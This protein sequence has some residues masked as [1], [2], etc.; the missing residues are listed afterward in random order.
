VNLASHLLVDGFRDR[1]DLAVI[2]SNDGDLKTPV[3]I[4]R[5]E[6]KVGVGIINPHVTRSLALSPRELP[7]GSFYQRLKP[8]RLASAQLPLE[9][10]D[11]EGRYGAPAAGACRRNNRAARG[12]L[13][14]RTA[15]KRPEGVRQL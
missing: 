11:E 10:R 8:R 2:V 6:L 5:R 12:R 9:L 4:V 7:A 1:Y 14:A 15:A 13:C 3:E